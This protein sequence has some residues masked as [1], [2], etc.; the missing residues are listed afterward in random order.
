MPPDPS[1]AQY[2]QS[3]GRPYG[4]DV[5]NIKGLGWTM[6]GNTFQLNFEIYDQ[7]EKVIAVI[8][9]KLISIK[10]KYAIDIYQPPYEAEVVAILIALQH[11]IRDDESA[12]AASSASYS[13]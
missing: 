1:I 11:T 12:S 9:Q 6:R 2:T 8:G 7:D 13:S 5:A 3:V 10:D 4:K